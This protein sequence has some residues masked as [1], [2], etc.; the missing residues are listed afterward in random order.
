MI[1]HC[2]RFLRTAGF[3]Q[4]QKNR[5]Y[6]LRFWNKPW[7]KYLMPALLAC[8]SAI[9]AS[10]QAPG[11]LWQT[12]VGA[13]LFAVDLQTNVYGN[14]AGTIIQMSGDGVPFQ[15]NI[16]CS[17]TNGIARL[18]NLGNRYLSGSFDGTQDF[19]G[20]TLVGGSKI[21]GQWTPGYPTCY[22]AKYAGNGSLQ[23]VMP[24][25]RYENCGHHANDL[26]INQDGSFVVA[27]DSCKFAQFAE[28][29]SSLSQLWTL[30]LSHGF[31][32]NAAF[33]VKAL[34]DTNGCFLRYRSDPSGPYIVGGFY[35]SAGNVTYYQP[36]YPSGSSYPRKPAWYNGLALNGRPAV[37]LT[38]D[39]YFAGLS[40][41]QPVLEK[42]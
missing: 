38:N 11:L 41:Q 40:S 14:L 22:V 33:A 39:G 31:P 34:T 23:W 29:S 21:F 30:E 4:G 42:T 35:D 26:V 5:R 10:G 18:D 32:D 7:S 8:A 6:K 2:W 1:K 19:G 36:Y 13:R 27:Y 12:N 15:T 28:Y 17:V 20:I 25:S 37:G 3:S 9:H 24:L 16:L